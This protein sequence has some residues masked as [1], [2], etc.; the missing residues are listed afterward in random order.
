MVLFQNN[1][2]N[3]GPKTRSNSQESYNIAMNN[4]IIQLGITVQNNQIELMQML[5]LLTG[6]Q[7]KI[8]KD[9]V[10]FTTRFDDIEESLLE[11]KNKNYDENIKEI[12]EILL[13]SQVVSIF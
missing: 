10:D 7:N 8:V 4:D 11:I 12:R 5:H 9:M 2:Q 13:S 3:N 6:M 1:N